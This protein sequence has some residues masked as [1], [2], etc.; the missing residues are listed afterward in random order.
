MNKNLS[1]N[2]LL[3]I[4]IAGWFTADTINGL[5]LGENDYWALIV[6]VLLWTARITLVLGLIGLIANLFRKNS[7]K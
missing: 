5:G 1:T 7:V 6:I 3:W 4:T 2:V